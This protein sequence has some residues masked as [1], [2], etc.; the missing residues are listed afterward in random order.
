MTMAHVLMAY[1][2]VVVVLHTWAL[3]TNMQG[4]ALLGTV[5]T[6]PQRYNEHTYVGPP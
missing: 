2:I 4:P 1:V 5:N 6:V 3:R